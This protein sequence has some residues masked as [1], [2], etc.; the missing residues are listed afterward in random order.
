MKRTPYLAIQPATKMVFGSAILG[1]DPITP[2]TDYVSWWLVCVRMLRDAITM[3][4]K[5]DNARNIPYRSVITFGLDLRRRSRPRTCKYIC[6]FMVKTEE[7]LLQPALP[8]GSPW[9]CKH[10]CMMVTLSRFSYRALLSTRT[11]QN[12]GLFIL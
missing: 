10:I 1:C 4:Y 11:K 5:A 7:R 6:P 3:L 9:A 2:Q 8:W 12:R